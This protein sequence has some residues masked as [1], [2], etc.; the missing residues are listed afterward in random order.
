MKSEAESLKMKGNLALQRIRLKG[1][2]DAAREARELFQ[3]RQ[4]RG[5]AT[6]EPSSADVDGLEQRMKAL[7]EKQEVEKKIEQQREGSSF[8]INDINIRNR[9]FQRM[10]EEKVG[11]KDLKEEQE[12][13]AGRAAVSDPFKRLPIR[14]V[15]YWDVKCANACVQAAMRGS[16]HCVR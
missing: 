4:M 8:R 6:V 5:D 11:H 3:Q 12:I 16:T 2:L 1:D 15:I 10:V 9:E 14:P 13:S 7:D